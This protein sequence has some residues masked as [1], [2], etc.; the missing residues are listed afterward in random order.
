MAISKI[1]SE[2]VLEAKDA[3]R[4]WQ[5]FA[6]EGKK[7]FNE[8][9]KAGDHANKGL[10]GGFKRGLASI[11]RDFAELSR[12]GRQL[13]ADMRQLGGAM[14]TMG[15]RMSMVALAAG[16]ATGAILA[17]AKAGT[18]AADAA[19]KA[20]QAVGMNI[21]AYGQLE[22][23]FEQSG[24]EAG[25]FAMA[26]SRLNDAI[27]KGDDASKETK[28]AFA[29]L[30]VSL[31]RT[32]GSARSTEEIL[33]DLADQFAKMPDGAEKSGAAIAI[34]G[35][36]IGPRLIPLLNQ[37]RRGMQALMEEAEKLGLTFT[38]QQFKISEAM[39][40][41]LNALKRTASAMRNQIGI[42]FAPT[43][44]R[45]AQSLTDA[46]VRNKE[47][48]LDF[49]DRAI[50]QA[51]ITVED[52]VAALSGRRQ[53][54]RQ[55][56][57]L[58]W[59][60]AVTDFATNVRSAIEGIVIPVFRGIIAVAE[61]VAQA[62]NA[63]FGTNFSG[64]VLLIAAGAL[65]LS[66]ALGVLWAAFRV[67]KSVTMALWAALN[68]LSIHPLMRAAII[69]AGLIAFVNNIRTGHRGAAEASEEHKAALMDLDRAINAVKEGLPG[70]ISE[71]NNISQAHL[72]AA[73]DALYNAKMQLE[74]QQNFEAMQRGFK[75]KGVVSDIL[76][77]GESD[78]AR[79]LREEIKRLGFEIDSIQNKIKEG[80]SAARGNV[81]GKIAED[82]EGT[83]EKVAAV[84]D[85]VEKTI[86][87][88]QGGSAGIT[89]EVFSVT[90]DGI[91]KLDG[92]AQD[93]TRGIAMFS[94]GQE[95]A[96]KQ[97]E[98][99]IK[100][101]KESVERFKEYKAALDSINKEI[102]KLRENRPTFDM[103]KPLTPAEQK[104]RERLL[105]RET[106]S[107][108]RTR[109]YNE[110]MKVYNKAVEEHQKKAIEHEQAIAD[111]EKERE[112]LK[113]KHA[114]EDFRARQEAKKAEEERRAAVKAEA[115]A[116]EER[117]KKLQE[118]A[119][120][121]EAG[122]DAL[123]ENM[124]EVKGSVGEVGE[125]I[126]Q[127]LV[128]DVASAAGQ[129]QEFADSWGGAATAIRAEFEGILPVI[130]DT[131]SK[132]N[133]AALEM[134]PVDWK[135]VLLG[136]ADA[137]AENVTSRINGAF[138][139]I[140]ES[141][142]ITGAAIQESLSGMGQVVDWPALAASAEA[143]F[144]GITQDAQQTSKE[145]QAALASGIDLSEARNR[146]N[147]AF[148]SIKEQ[149][150]S[151]A[152]EV[153]E[154]FAGIGQ[155]VDW[156][157][158]Q[159]SV[160]TVFT[161]ITEAARIVADNIREAFEGIAV[162]IR[163]AFSGLA[164]SIRIELAAVSSAASSMISRIISELQDLRNALSA[165]KSQLNNSG[166]GGNTTLGY[167]GGGQVR[168][169]G[170]S[171]SDSIPARLSRGEF[172][173]RAQAVKHYGAELFAAL[174]GMRAPLP[175]FS[176]GGAV[177]ANPG[178]RF[179]QGGMVGGGRGDG[180]SFATINLSIG[181]ETFPGLMAPRDT[182]FQLVRYAQ[183]EK[184]RRAGKRP[185]WWK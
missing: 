150:V 21:K 68:L 22:Y 112:E 24:I 100:A 83:V 119:V 82:A 142:A 101:T 35:Q 121:A 96:T 159:I 181:D 126:N 116:E 103:E 146:V 52:F 172:V 31:K 75:D 147:E 51:T 17:M 38:E 69:G 53:D 74:A 97:A 47:A 36:R 3:V 158:L 138:D 84:K 85:E 64:E 60:D 48:I 2:V 80:R 57:V 81:V 1:I 111:K 148:A 37:G 72:K 90:A 132:V 92:A 43:I 87:L 32:D 141:A 151:S 117:T 155:N 99:L 143:T 71:L 128:A 174:N 106:D 58:V 5:E 61:K 59:T 102:Q 54:V 14:S 131:M 171:T 161:A 133:G 160:G 91:K 23:A 88:I 6:N 145:I 120:A 125:A 8:V 144:D 108:R 182:A 169:P 41:T 62:I 44:T 154:S 118:Q 40:D 98:W 134:A 55:P 73:E 176:F 180:G 164:D 173:I 25:Q 33:A 124:D 95:T 94:D 42:M 157:A 39:N 10:S 13:R 11:K 129:S 153:N 152:Q 177:I 165:I 45:L 56:W 114:A 163:G 179:A 16:A 76:G 30:G 66:G 166:G 162:S 79:A 183:S 70:A 86:T 20:A 65:Q 18:N 122:T 184:I 46:L 26:M 137:V 139:V 127:A 136:D 15:K 7:T 130:Q 185:G 78:E 140:Q 4:E 89:K 67:G 170:T 123:I 175:K 149:G 77:G 27:S 104:A 49:A 19:G 113:K 28:D 110:Q 135:A 93:A 9:K 34:F 109:E 63:M 168:G 167:A 156:D 105:A 107:Q 50:Q 115:A 12:H 178:L 29:K